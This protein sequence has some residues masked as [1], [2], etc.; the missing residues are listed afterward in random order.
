[1]PVSALD[2]SAGVMSNV[3]PVYVGVE[4]SNSDPHTCMAVTLSTE[5]S[6]QPVAWA[7]SLF[8]LE[9]VRTA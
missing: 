9:N 4:V 1:M 5:L 3:S 2:L 8:L 7:A 6:S